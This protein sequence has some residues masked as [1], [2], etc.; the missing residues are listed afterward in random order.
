MEEKKI[1]EAHSLLHIDS[2]DHVRLRPKM[3][4]EKCFQDNNLNVIILGAVCHA[5]DEYSDDNCN[6]II[7]NTEAMSF[8]VKYNA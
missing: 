3:Y 1:Y 8:T 4:F 7:I 2:S 5:I 6:E